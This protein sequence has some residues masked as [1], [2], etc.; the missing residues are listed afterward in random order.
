MNERTALITG[1]SMGMGRRLAERLAGRGTF[2]VLCAN[3][4][5]LLEEEREKIERAGGRAIAIPVD[6][7]DADWI[8][9]VVQHADEAVGGLDLVVANAGIG[10][11]CDGRQMTWDKIAPII[12]TN[13]VGTI[14]TITAALPGMLRRGHGHVLAMSSLAGRRGLPTVSHYCASKVAISRFLEGLRID[15]A[16]TGIVVTDVQPGFVDSAG[17][18]RKADYPMPVVLGLEPAVDYIVKAIDTH[19]PV[20]AFPPSLAMAFGA[21]G[22]VP[23][24]V[25]ERAAG[26]AIRRK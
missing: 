26:W 16:G 17:T 21:M 20:M 9:E 24:A 13:V 22:W 5:E 8:T 2:V 19:A 14:A 3:T 10:T 23:R 6:I 7:R 12:Q 18:G 15:L 25:F 1:A 11:P 4:P